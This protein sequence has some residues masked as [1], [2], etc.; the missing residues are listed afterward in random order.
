MMPE[1]TTGCYNN[2]FGAGA[3]LCNISGCYGI[4]SLVIMQEVKTPL[5]DNNFF[6]FYGGYYNTTGCHNNFLGRCAEL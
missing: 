3:G 6:G 4:T 1:N 2:F 5:D